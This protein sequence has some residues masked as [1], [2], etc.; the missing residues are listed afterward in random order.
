MMTRYEKALYL[1]L[2]SSGADDLFT[3]FI[4][5][6]NRINSM[7]KPTFDIDHIYSSK[8]EVLKTRNAELIYEICIEIASQ[9]ELINKAHLKICLEEYR[10]YGAFGFHTAYQRIH[11]EINYLAMINTPTLKLD[12]LCTIYI[13]SHP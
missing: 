4:S 2:L 12:T 5:L 8:M 9:M 11:G 3:R 10:T 13:F 1:Y 6:A 7:G